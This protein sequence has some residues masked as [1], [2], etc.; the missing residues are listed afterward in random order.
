MCNHPAFNAARA[1]LAPTAFTAF[2][3]KKYAQSIFIPALMIS[4]AAASLFLICIASQPNVIV[5][6]LWFMEDAHHW[7]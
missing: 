5:V 3:E 2:T 7:R 4:V 1:I 6:Q